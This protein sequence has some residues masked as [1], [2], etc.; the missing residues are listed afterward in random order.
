[1][2]IVVREGG[3]AGVRMCTLCLLRPSTTA[4]RRS[5]RG[6]GK[7]TLMVVGA[8]ALIE[9]L[10]FSVNCQFS[11]LMYLTGSNYLHPLSTEL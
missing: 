8:D 9:I 2:S 1:M 11:P 7:A 6:S 10:E 5:Y 4:V 3:D